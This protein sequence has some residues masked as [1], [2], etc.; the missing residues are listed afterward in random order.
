MMY[1]TFVG[2]LLVVSPLMFVLGLFVDRITRRESAFNYSEKMEKMTQYIESFLAEVLV[3]ERN[4]RSGIGE[5]FRDFFREMVTEGRV[6][7]ATADELKKDPLFISM[8]RELFG[9]KGSKKEMVTFVSDWCA[10]YMRSAILDYEI[11]YQKIKSGVDNQYENM[12]E[13]Q[14]RLSDELKNLD[15]TC[16]IVLMD[17]VKNR[18]RIKSLFNDIYND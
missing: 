4:S 1:L 17:A 13:A 8:Y 16:E 11:A 15:F 5:S 3:F 14:N 12:Y 7:R 2:I 18:L 6:L 10:K 9:V